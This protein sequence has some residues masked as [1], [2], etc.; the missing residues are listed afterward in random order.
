MTWIKTVDPTKATGLLQT[1]FRAAVKRAGKVYQI[2]QIQSLHPKALRVT[3][4]LYNELMHGAE[5]ALSRKRR[6]LIATVVSRTNEC[7]Y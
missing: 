6:E 2:I 3:T 1:L 5:G 7:F 4:Q